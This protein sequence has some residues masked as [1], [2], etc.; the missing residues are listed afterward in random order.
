MTTFE[1]FSQALVKRS[2]AM[3][4]F[5]EVARLADDRFADVGPLPE[6]GDIDAALAQLPGALRAAEDPF[7]FGR[8]VLFAGY[9][10]EQGGHVAEVAAG[11]P[12]RSLGPK[13]VVKRW[14]S[15]AVS[16]SPRA[17]SRSRRASTISTGARGRARGGPKTRLLG[18]FGGSSR[19]A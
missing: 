1:A 4:F 9:L 2:E 5:D 19:C 16:G 11:G 17:S 6:A 8:L 13:L 15:P 10:A 3:L 14:P 12:I 7:N 18:G